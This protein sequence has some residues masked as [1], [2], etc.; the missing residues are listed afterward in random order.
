MVYIGK[1]YKFTPS[2]NVGS[3]SSF[4]CNS[5]TSANMPI[6]VEFSNNEL[7]ITIN[8]LLDQFKSGPLNVTIDFNGT[9]DFAPGSGRITL[10]PL[11]ESY[12]NLYD[13]TS[14]KWN[15]YLIK[16]Y[17]NNNWRSCDAKVHKKDG[18]I[19]KWLKL[20]VYDEEN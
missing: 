16:V 13:S 19:H 20:G 10:V 8:G 7:Y 11:Q 14:K 15:T 3:Y 12:V 4:K 6:N 18:Q 1:K 2:G 5:Y 9:S 17:D